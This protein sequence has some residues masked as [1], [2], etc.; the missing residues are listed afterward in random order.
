[1]PGKSKPIVL[2]YKRYHNTCTSNVHFFFAFQSPGYDKVEEAIEA[3]KNASLDD[4]NIAEMIS[5]CPFGL[6]NF[7]CFPLIVDHSSN[8]KI[9]G[10]EIKEDLSQNR[11]IL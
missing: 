9:I 5:T 11:R 4:E 10:F 1:V 6:V 7:L 8:A 3:A 2:D